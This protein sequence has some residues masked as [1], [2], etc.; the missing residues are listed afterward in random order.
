[1]IFLD[2]F[3]A[4][5]QFA[6]PRFR[7]VLWLGV[8]LTIALLVAVYSLFL[9]LM[10]PT[11]EGDITLPII[12]PVS[13]LGDLLSWGSL[14]LM[15]ILSVFLMIPVASAI[16]SFFLDDVAEAVEDMHYPH[17]PP[18]P[19]TPFYDSVKDTV[20][21]L[22]ILIAANV[23]AFAIYAV[24]PFLSVFIF[25]A[26]NGFLLG[27][28]YFQ[29]AAMRRL[30]REGA[31]ELRRQNTGK[32]WFAGCLMALPLSIPLINLFIPILG[33]A[34]FTHLYHRISGTAATSG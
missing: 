25:F 27:R 10:N 12:G 19:R 24:V 26:L 16:T 7:R 17:L 2:F 15:L 32:I 28:E 29:V 22:G 18:V 8:G 3:K 20:N 30:G 23:L 5:S 13:W 9:W 34:T 21:F 14:G 33:A 31:K 6:D 11:F 1:M 4:F